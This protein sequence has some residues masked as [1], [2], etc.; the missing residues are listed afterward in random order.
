MP[1]SSCRDCC[2]RYEGCH[3]VCDSYKEYKNRIE[4]TRE[5]IKEDNDFMGY[6]TDSIRRMRR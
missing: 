3:S 1:S 5:K 2:Q 6:L 4:Q